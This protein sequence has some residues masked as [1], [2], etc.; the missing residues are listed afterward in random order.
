MTE[1]ED[2]RARLEKLEMLAAEQDRTIEDLNQTITSQWREIEAL[3]RQIAKLD[4]EL[5]EVE[6]GMPALPIQKPPHY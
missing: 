4:D 3:R 1:S 5:R 6:A 2:F